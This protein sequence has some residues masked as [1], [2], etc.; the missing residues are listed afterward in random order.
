MINYIAKNDF[1]LVLNFDVDVDDIVGDIGAA[2]GSF[3]LSIVEKA[4]KLYLFEMDE[5]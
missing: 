1:D 2:E 3:G 5:E 4:K